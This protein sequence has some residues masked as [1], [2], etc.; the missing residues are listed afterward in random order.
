M[1]LL[2]SILTVSS[3]FPITNKEGVCVCVCVVGRGGGAS[4]RGG[5]GAKKYALYVQASWIILSLYLY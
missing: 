5:G 3:S 2:N 4:G 1:L